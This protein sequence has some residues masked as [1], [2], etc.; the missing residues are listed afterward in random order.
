M[1]ES[2][3]KALEEAKAEARDSEKTEDDLTD[4]SEPAAEKS[5]EQVVDKEEEDEKKQ[6][7][8]FDLKNMM[9]GFK[10]ELKKSVNGVIK[11]SIKKAVEENK[12]EIMKAKKGKSDDREEQEE[13]SDKEECDSTN[14]DR[15]SSIRDQAGPTGKV[16]NGD[17]SDPSE[18]SPSLKDSPIERNEFKK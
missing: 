2:T 13:S 15:K 17:A 11:V 4:K 5:S 14:D 12:A 6:D 9:E 8:S 18:A 1:K 7:D 10:T 3:T 16:V